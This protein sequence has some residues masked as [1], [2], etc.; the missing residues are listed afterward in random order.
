M[1]YQDGLDKLSRR[2]T[3][4]VKL[5][6]DSETY[7]LSSGEVP[8]D[9][10]YYACI[11]NIDWIPT[12]ANAEGG[13]G[14]FGQ[15]VIKCTDFPYSQSGG[16]GTYFG[17]MLADNKYFLNR[18]I[19]VY[20]GYLDRGETFSLS[21]FQKRTYL[22]KRVDG[23]NDRGSVAFYASDVISQL[24]ETKIPEATSGSLNA[25][26]TDSATGSTNITDNTGFSASGGFA[27][28]NDEIIAYSGVTGADSITISSRGQ[29]GST[30]SAHDAGDSVR[31]IYKS[32]GSNVVDEIR[33]LIEDYSN[34]DHATYLP[35]ADWNTERDGPLASVNV[36]V[37]ITEPT[38][39]SDVIDS[40]C[41]DTLVNV[42]W[43]DA[44]QEIKLKSLGPTPTVSTTWSDSDNILDKPSKVTVKRD[45]RKILSEVWVFFGKRDQA[46]GD[47]EE[48]YD[49]TYIKIDS[50]I[51]T[52]LGEKK[53][54]KIIA[55]NI[56]AGASA[57]ASKI[58]SRFITQ[59][60]V[61]IE[62]TCY[63]DAKDSTVDVGDSINISTDLIL[64]TD[65]QPELTIMRVIEKAQ[66]ENGRYFYKLIKTGQEAG[67]RYPVIG[68]NTL[69]VYTS[70]S[71]AQKEKY[72]WICGNDLDM[73]NGDDP[74]LI[75]P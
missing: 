73:S 20:V 16:A 3:I 6:L 17:R 72:G 31:D 66:K 51:Q 50:D 22:L 14:Y 13:L 70:A 61:P 58:A 59:N 12:R 52:G 5:N 56:P 63:V 21:N 65:G 10:H 25:G 39:L 48:N 28:I 68:P 62:F 71:T 57:S 32:T 55:K 45:H 19:D 47:T 53:V 1:T 60:E 11:K 23:P 41:K 36:D 9:Q 8:T 54:K 7:W 46:G 49:D 44:A 69:P 35:D 2:Q 34:I 30:A 29:G 67:S 26:I 74:Y 27:I 37:W 15:I 4:L 33:T 40:L 24:K 42:W 64:G 43:D 18:L 75:W 38:D